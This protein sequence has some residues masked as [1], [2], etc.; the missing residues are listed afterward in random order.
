MPGS[1]VSQSSADTRIAVML[2][3]RDDRKAEPA[4]LIGFSA[5]A[6]AVIGDFLAPPSAIAF[7][8]DVAAWATVPKTAVD[9]DGDV[10]VGEH[11][12]GSSRQT[13]GSRCVSDTQL[14][15]DSA[16]A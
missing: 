15:H 6:A 1:G 13:R 12:V 10:V 3:Q 8:F 11:E 9:E 16:Y 5:V 14:P 4:Q 2:H 7:R